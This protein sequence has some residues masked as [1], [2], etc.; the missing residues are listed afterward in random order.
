M[1]R[2]VVPDQSSAGRLAGIAR[3]AFNGHESLWNASDFMALGGPPDA[4]IIVD[5]GFS[6]ALL[7]MRM[8]ADEAEILNFGVVPS[9]RRKGLGRELLE[10]AKMLARQSGIKRIFLEVAVDNAAAMALYAGSGFIE[11]G[12]R[13]A[14]YLRPGGTRVDALI[15]SREI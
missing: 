2:V 10:A 12:K 4:A 15:L 13:K 14:Y 1:A 9:A 11:A 6:K 8:A 3:V 7:V 5:D